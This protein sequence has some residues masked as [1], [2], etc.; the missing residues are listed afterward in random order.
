MFQTLRNAFKVKD[1]RS[2]IFYT[3]LMLV[4]VRLGSQLPIPGVDR[5]YF[6]TGSHS[7]WEMHSTSLMH[8]PVDL[9]KRCQFLH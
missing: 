1:I 3:F 4:V 7:R 5:S 9:L 6:A 8:L 2:K